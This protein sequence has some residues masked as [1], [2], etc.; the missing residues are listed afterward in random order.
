M[1]LVSVVL[2]VVVAEGVPYRVS[3]T[4]VLK[5]PAV[6]EGHRTSYPLFHIQSMP[7]LLLHFVSVEAV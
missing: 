1:V 5:I 4:V 6:Q 3:A 2:E 7:Y